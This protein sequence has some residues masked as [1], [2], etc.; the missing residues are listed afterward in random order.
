MHKKSAIV[1][2]HRRSDDC[3]RKTATDR[4]SL[5]KE[6]FDMHDSF[7]VG[8][9]HYGRALAIIGVV[10]ALAMLVHLL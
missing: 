6:A 9:V 4:E 1:L 8:G 2:P 10:V 3:I 5:E 7:S